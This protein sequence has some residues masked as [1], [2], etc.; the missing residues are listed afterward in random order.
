MEESSTQDVADVTNV[1]DLWRR[2]PG[3]LQTK[4]VTTLLCQQ[5]SQLSE[6]RI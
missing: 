1:L 5:K 6:E 4:I 3:E 2:L